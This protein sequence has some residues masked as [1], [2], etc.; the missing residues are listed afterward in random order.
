MSRSSWKLARSVTGVAQE[1]TGGSRVRQTGAEDGHGWEPELRRGQSVWH[2][3]AHDQDAGI[4]SRP[5]QAAMR[6]AWR[7]TGELRRG[8][9]VPPS[10][11]L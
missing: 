2:A 10:G 5:G 4:D 1:L 7:G 9:V 3:L 6:E 11:R 8:V